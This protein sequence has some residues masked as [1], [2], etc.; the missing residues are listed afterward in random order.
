LKNPANNIPYVANDDT[1]NINS[2]PNSISPRDNP[3]PYLMQT[4]LIKHFFPYSYAFEFLLFLKHLLPTKSSTNLSSFF[5][6]ISETKHQSLKSK[7]FTPNTGL[8]LKKGIIISVI[9][10]NLVTLKS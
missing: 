9:S 10:E 7:D 2:I 8:F 6:T 1:A 4:V 3:G 5:F